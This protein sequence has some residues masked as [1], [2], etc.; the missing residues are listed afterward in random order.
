MALGLILSALGGAGQNYVEQ[1]KA[2]AA[3]R[4][5]IAQERRAEAM[6][7]AR[8]DRANLRADAVYSRERGDFVADRDDN[9]KYNGE[10]LADQRAYEGT[11]RAEDRQFRKEDKLED[12]AYAEQVAANNAA[13]SERNRLRDLEDKKAFANYTSGLRI[14]ETKAKPNTSLGTTVSND[15]INSLVTLANIGDDLAF[16]EEMIEKG[17]GTNAVGV[18]NGRIPVSALEI[19]G[20]AKEEDIKFRA[21]LAKVSSMQI[22]ELAGAAVS[23]SEK[24]RLMNFLPGPEDTIKV[25]REKS[26]QFREEADKIIRAKVYGVYS[27][28]NGYRNFEI[29]GYGQNRS[30]SAGKS[31]AELGKQG[32]LNPDPF[33]EDDAFFSLYGK[34][35]AE[36]VG[37][38]VFNP[39]TGDFFVVSEQ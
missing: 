13:A 22:K 33:V 14:Q 39:E 30:T 10:L 36:L 19:T 2:L 11:I 34:T 18:V 15:T 35:R 27:Q 25:I 6:Q 9:R 3:E 28:E 32:E 1:S 12:R 16:V 5:Q 17:K 26:R 21:L 38:E 8:E 20:V 29:P 4:S 31:E 37:K 23:E 7:I 24:N